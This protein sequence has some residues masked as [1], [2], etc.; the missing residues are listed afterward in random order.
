MPTI[1]SASCIHCRIASHFRSRFLLPAL[2]IQSIV[3]E[4]TT[5]DM[6]DAIEA[7]PHDLHQAFYQTLARI[8]RQ[9]DG[10][11]RLGMNVLLWMSHAKGSLTVA[12]LSEAM[13]VKPGNTSVNSRHRPSQNMMIECC[14]GLVTVDQESSS[15]HLVHYALQEF[16]RDQREEIFPSGEDQIA[17]ICIGYIFFDEF[18]CGCCETEAE[19][20]RLMK[21][22]P[23]LRYASSYWG[24]HVQSS[25]CDR[26]YGLALEL[27]HSAPRRA[28]SIQITRFSQGF[29]AKYWEP[30]EVTSHDAFHYACGF[31]LESAVCNILESE[32]IDV[33]AATHIGTTALIRAASSGHVGLVKLLMSR[34]ADPTKANWY[35]SA[36][37]CAAEAGQCESIRFLLDSGMNIDLRDDF[38]RTPLHCAADQRHI[39]AIELLLDMGADPNTRDHVGGKLIHDAAQIGDE[40]LMRRLLR[41][42]RVDISATTVGGKKGKT[43]LHCAAMGGHAGIVR[44]LLDVGVEIDAKDGGGYTALHLAAW[45]GEEDVVRL[46]VE[47]GANVNAKSDGKTT[48]RYLAAAA[49][50]ESIQELLLE[51]GA[52]KGVF[53]YLVSDSQSAGEDDVAS[54]YGF[55]N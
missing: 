29:R 3:N 20:V 36:L 13:A 25:H 16:F 5:G 6:E 31:G 49:N 37:H 21:D 26:I 53:E 8:Q 24:H 32:D 55:E 10:R 43:A 39:L 9:S 42:E 51:H 34:G 4:P 35:G 17:D 46:L 48:A 54:R 44:M 18:V 47:A 33:D 23:L 22:F 27:L 38:G 50:H 1:F 41:D 40:R 28:L 45:G 19:I 11:K 12:E 15:I 14:M 30:D 2:Q 7:M 52:E